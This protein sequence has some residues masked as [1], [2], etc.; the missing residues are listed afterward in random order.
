MSRLRSKTSSWELTALIAA[1]VIIVSLPVYYFLVV[2]DLS[3]TDVQD[4]SPTFVGSVE[5]QDCHNNEYDRWVDP[6]DEDRA[7]RVWP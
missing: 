4:T 1:L 6:V 5:C 3:E 7:S 2:R